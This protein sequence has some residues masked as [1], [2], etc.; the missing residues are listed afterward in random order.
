MA[1][2]LLREPAGAQA[3]LG[4]LTC[5]WE[6]WP[7]SPGTAETFHSRAPGTGWGTEGTHVWALPLEGPHGGAVGES[8]LEA[9]PQMG[10]KGQMGRSGRDSRREGAQHGGIKRCREDLCGAYPV[11]PSGRCFVEWVSWRVQS[12]GSHCPTPGKRAQAGQEAVW[13]RSGARAAI[14]P[15]AARHSKP[16]A[17]RSDRMSLL[18]F[19]HLRVIPL[20]STFLVSGSTCNILGKW[21][22]SVK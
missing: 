4:S 18:T 5:S 15:L 10:L 17:I 8:F 14:L 7:D 3:S 2:V 1:E 9:I 6:P 12:P 11:I 21:S 20:C 13:S 16:S 22:S 19:H